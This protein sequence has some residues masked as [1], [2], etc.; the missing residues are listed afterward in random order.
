MAIESSTSASTLTLPAWSPRSAAVS[1]W[2]WL[3]PPVAD[4]SV[5]R[6]QEQRR[7]EAERRLVHAAAELVG[8]IRAGQGDARQRRR[9]RGIQPRPRDASLRVQGCVDAAARR[10]GHQSVPRRCVEESRSDSPIDQLRHLIDFYFRVVSD[11]QP[12]NRARLVL[13]ADA[14]AGPSQDVNR[15]DVPVREFREE[16]E[17]RI[18][19]A[20]GAGDVRRRRPRWSGDGDRCDAERCRLATCTRRPTRSR[21]GARRNRTT[22]RRVW[23]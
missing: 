20:V 15:R 10:R 17:K 21:R 16:I 2:R 1:C 9:A 23:G 22:V 6:T 12:V 4:S 19:L 5:P 7:I 11:L 3:E 13:W 8:E 18:E 14:V